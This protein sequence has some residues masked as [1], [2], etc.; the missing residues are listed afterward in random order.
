MRKP[1]IAEARCTRIQISLLC[2][3]GYQLK[4]LKQSSTGSQGKIG[5][6]NKSLVDKFDREMNQQGRGCGTEAKVK[7]LSCLTN[8][9]QS[10][11]LSFMFC[12]ECNS[13]KIGLLHSSKSTW[14]EWNSNKEK[15][16]Q[17]INHLE[18]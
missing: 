11:I 4:L 1:D 13:H 15:K 3:S 17:K 6:L 9:E 12:F 18:L 8:T 2:P 10:F 7:D 16:I 5:Y 14:F